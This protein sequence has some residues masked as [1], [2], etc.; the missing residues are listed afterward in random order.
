MQH[1]ELSADKMT[2]IHICESVYN[3][4]IVNMLGLYV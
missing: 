4:I 2:L 1:S 3:D